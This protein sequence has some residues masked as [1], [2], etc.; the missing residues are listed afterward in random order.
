MRNDEGKPGIWREWNQTGD[1]PALPRRPPRQSLVDLAYEAV[2]EAIV[3]RRIGS[4]VRNGIDALAA[5]LDMSA[6]P[7]REALARASAKG[8][9]VQESNRGFI[10]APFL[11]PDEYGDLWDTRRLLELHALEQAR[12]DDASVARLS[13]I[14]ARMPSMDHGPVYRGFREFSEADREF[15]HT[16]V[17]MASNTFL[18]RA[19]D[20]LHFHL[21]VGR[22]YA[23]QGLIDFHDALREHDAIVGLLRARD[24]SSAAQELARHIDGARA[25]L[26]PLIEQTGSDA[27]GAA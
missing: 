19:W 2:V 26:T 24:I 22:I 14:I 1:S 23:G 4:G 18:V 12:V 11:S 3:D 9:V 27:A 25:R 7:V 16:L 15:H 20:D 13:A 6:T 21:H 17:A 8:L 10:V 5:R